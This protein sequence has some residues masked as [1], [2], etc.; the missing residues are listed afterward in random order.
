MKRVPIE[1]VETGEVIESKSQAADLFGVCVRA[2]DFA[3]MR[4]TRCGGYQIRVAQDQQT[5]NGGNQNG[6]G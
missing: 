4:G 2:V 3:L 6:E 5:N 1:I